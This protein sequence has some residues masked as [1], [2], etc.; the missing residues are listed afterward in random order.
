MTLRGIVWLAL[1]FAVAAALATFGHFNTGQVL[2]IYPPYRVDL[3]LNF[4]VLAL[5]VLF[6]ALYALTRIVRNIWRMPARVAAYRARV[7]YEKAHDALRDALAHLYA[8]RFARAEK[9]AGNAFAVDVNRGAASLVAASAAHR[10]HEY[11]RRDEWLAKADAPDWQEARLLASAD[12]RAEAR[13]G[14]GALDALA[15]MRASGGKRI[16]AL[17]V[18]LRAHQQLRNWS[19]V[20]K[21]SKT[22]EKRDAL[23]PAAAERLRQQAAEHLLRERRHDADAL[24]ETWQ[25]LS[26]AERQIPGLADL[27]AELL[28]ALDRKPEARRIVEN[29]LAQ[30]WDARLL[31]RYPETADADVLPLIQNAETWQ[32]QHP[33]DADLQYALGRLCQAQQLWGKAQSFLETALKLADAPAQKADAHRALAA[34]YEELGETGRAAEHYREGAL[35]VA[36]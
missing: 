18:A 33:D 29:A 1:L 10:M 5:I 2:V 28:I 36:R 35:A 19:E 31:R 17:Q 30:H 25:S 12:M 8:G 15:Q 22:L 27:A 34:L 6:F 11:A 32:R 4:C 21:L 24:L 13:D 14:Q 16:Q 20:L 26:A 9:A 7:R 3:S 23:H